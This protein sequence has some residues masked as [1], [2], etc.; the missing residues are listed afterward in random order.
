MKLV[1]IIQESEDR[2]ELSPEIFKSLQHEVEVLAKDPDKMWPSAL[3][4]LHDA[5]EVVGVERPTPAMRAA[6]VQY[7]ELMTNSVQYLNKYQP[8]GNWRIT[9]VNSKIHI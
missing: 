2:S 6:W 9:T 5:Y 8:K 1:D 3:A 4:L 7:E